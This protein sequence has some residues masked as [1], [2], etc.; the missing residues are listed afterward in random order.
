M[1]KKNARI[2]KLKKI[3]AGL[4]AKNEALETIIDNT[5]A[6]LVITTSKNVQLELEESKKF[7]DILIDN[8]NVMIIGINNYGNVVLFNKAAER[9]S[10]FSNQ[11]VIGENWFGRL[12]TPK[13]SEGSQLTIK[14]VIIN[15]G[16]PEVYENSLVTKNGMKKII[17]WQNTTL[18]GNNVIFR[19]KWPGFGSGGC[20]FSVDMI[21]V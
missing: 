21:K 6:S 10:G 14:E 12:I 8:A 15:N 2:S 17:S 5:P 18:I 4:K 9:I 11:E 19:E 7:N 16:I 1:N 3:I 13:M 20:P